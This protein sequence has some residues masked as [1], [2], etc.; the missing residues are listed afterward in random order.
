MS[1]HKQI[2]ILRREITA[3]KLQLRDQK[4]SNRRKLTKVEVQNIFMLHRNTSLTTR[5]IADMY[6]VNRSTIYRTLK[7]VYHKGAA[8]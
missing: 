4:V 2:Q 3:L 5:E 8:A 1:P 7:G 6:D